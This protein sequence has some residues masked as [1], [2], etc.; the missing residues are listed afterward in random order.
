MLAS[1]L[2]VLLIF[3]LPGGLLGLRLPAWNWRTVVG[4]RNRV[5]EAQ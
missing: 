5:P 4:L 1:M 2:V 3:T